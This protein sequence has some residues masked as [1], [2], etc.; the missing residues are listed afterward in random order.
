M[1]TYGE[2]DQRE[3]KKRGRRSVWG[4]GSVYCEEGENERGIKE[5]LGFRIR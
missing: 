5:R 3:R 1:Y 4:L 2:S